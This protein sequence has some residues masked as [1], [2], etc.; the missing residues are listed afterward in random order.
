MTIIVHSERRMQDRP[1]TVAT[2]PWHVITVAGTEVRVFRGIDDVHATE[3]DSIVPPDD[4]Q[5]SHA[6]IRA[7]QH[8]RVEDAEHWHLMMYRAGEL[9]GV[10]TLSLVGIRLDLLATG[11]TRRTIRAVRRVR[12]SLLRPAVLLCGLPVSAGRPCLA[13]R[14]PEDAPHVLRALGDVMARIGAEAGADLHCVKEFTDAE[15]GVMGGLEAHGYFHAASLPSFRL[16]I[17]WR[18]F[19]EYLA[20]MRAGYRRQ[21]QLLLRARARARLRIRRVDAYERECHRIF[22]LYEQVIDQAEFR[23]ERLNLRFFENLARYLPNR[24]AAI[25]VEREDRLLAVAIMLRTPNEL[26]FLMAGID[27]ARNRECSAYLNL[28][29]EIVAEAIRTGAGSLEL[30]QTSPALK[31][32]L[33]ARAEARHIYFRCPSRMGHTAFRSTASALFPLADSPR[34]RVFRSAAGSTAR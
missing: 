2:E 6:F 26:T 17:A 32:R 16:P 29:L 15:A 9:A 12:P 25:M 28:V 24:T 13:I 31:A 19:D 4:V 23:L 20:D 1:D 7:C 3:W 33:G 8:A 22:P 18:S 27:Y 14:G 5:A 34:R 21:A 11:L 30:G 10:A